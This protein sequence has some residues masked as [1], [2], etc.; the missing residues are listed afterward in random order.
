MRKMYSQKWLY[1]NI[2]NKTKE[3]KSK[4]FFWHIGPV[5]NIMYGVSSWTSSLNASIGTSLIKC[6]SIPDMSPIRATWLRLFFCCQRQS[7]IAWANCLQ[8]CKSCTEGSSHFK[9]SC[10]SSFWD[11]VFT[12]VFSES[13]CHSFCILH[14]I[15]FTLT[16]THNVQGDVLVKSALRVETVRWR[17][18]RGD[19][20][21]P[22]VL[23]STELWCQ[24]LRDSLWNTTIPYTALR[25]TS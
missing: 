16:T 17:K 21:L 1:I 20:I 15:S 7:Y 12:K 3:W 19:E 6:K 24:R 13:R 25:H 5:S 18:R 8:R 11:I 9:R 22:T 10:F 14:W 23:F 2:W 4:E